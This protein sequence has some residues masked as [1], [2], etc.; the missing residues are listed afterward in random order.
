ME[1]VVRDFDFLFGGTPPD[2]GSATAE[3]WVKKI[4]AAAGSPTV[5]IVNGEAKLSLD[6]QNEVQ[7]LCLYMADALPF[8]ID[9]IQQIDIWARCSASL[10]AA[11]S[12]AFGLGS[13]RN[14]A[15]DSIAQHALF[16]V[17]GDG[18]TAGPV[19]VETDDGVNDNDDEATGQ[20][21]AATLKRF[22]IDLAS[23]IK[24]VAPPGKSV[25]GKGNV[26]FSVDDD[27]GNLQPV[28]RATLFDMSNYASGLQLFAQIQKTAA[29][30][31][32]DLYIKRF[33]VRYRAY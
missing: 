19:T 28:A 15:I 29:T 14:D 26:L 32:G 33:R 18:E 9:D 31:T 1:T 27:R 5:S 6:S 16:R 24:T 10:N 22:T 2:V 4:T 3:G 7:N 13:A 12:L 11:V 30:A 23:G 20:T 25:G 21:L 17:L 8:D